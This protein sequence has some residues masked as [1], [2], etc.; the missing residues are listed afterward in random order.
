MQR[1]RNQKKLDDL[2]ANKQHIQSQIEDAKKLKYEALEEYKKE[3]LQVDAVVQRMIE[4]DRE[5][6]RITQ[7]KMEQAQADMILS[8]NEKR[9]LLKR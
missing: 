4:E 6:A 2:R 7:Q 3:K 8:V 1:E 9:A 5:M